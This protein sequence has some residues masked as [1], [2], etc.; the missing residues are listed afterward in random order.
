MKN[1]F[2]G[3][4]RYPFFCTVKKRLVVQKVFSIFNHLKIV[5]A[6]S[7]VPVQYHKQKQ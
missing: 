7:V 6:Y 4:K 5:P 3:Y 1:D 2:P